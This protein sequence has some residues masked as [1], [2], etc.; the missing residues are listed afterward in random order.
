[1]QA[2]AQVEEE[3]E[4]EEL[5]EEAEGEERRQCCGACGEIEEGRLIVQ[6]RDSTLR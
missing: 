5:E 4:E 3:E 2:Q 1:M 6:L